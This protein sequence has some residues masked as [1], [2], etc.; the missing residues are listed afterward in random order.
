ML[1][2]SGFSQRHETL[3]MFVRVCALVCVN[4]KSVHFCVVCTDTRVSM[5]A[6]TPIPHFNFPV[7]FQR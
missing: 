1:N 4:R 7:S 5:C 3:L 6:P 2:I